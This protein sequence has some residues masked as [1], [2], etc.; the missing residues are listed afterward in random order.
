[1]ATQIAMMKR[2]PRTIPMI[3][4]GTTVVLGLDS[5]PA[6]GIVPFELAESD[7]EAEGG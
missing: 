3:V 5:P 2:T 7:E 4:P 6:A 1:M